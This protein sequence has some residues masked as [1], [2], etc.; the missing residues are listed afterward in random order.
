M[1]YQKYILTRSPQQL[2]MYTALVI[3]L[4]FLLPIRNAEAKV[5]VTTAK[6]SN[7]KFTDLYFMTR[8]GKARFGSYDPFFKTSH[9]QGDKSK[10]EEGTETWNRLFRS[11]V[12]WPKL[13]LIKNHPE[14]FEGIKDFGAN[15]KPCGISET[16]HPAQMASGVNLKELYLTALAESLQKD[17]YKKYF[18]SD[19]PLF[20][21]P[22]LGVEPYQN[23]CV[24]SNVLGGMGADEFRLRRIHN[25]LATGIY[26]EFTDYAKKITLPSSGYL[27]VPSPLPDYDFSNKVF[28]M[29]LD[30]GMVQ[31]SVIQPKNIGVRPFY[32]WLPT[33]D[34]EIKAAEHPYMAKNELD[35]I[36]QGFREGL[37]L[38][39]I[40]WTLDVEKAEAVSVTAQ[41]YMSMAQKRG[42]GYRY[43][44]KSVFGVVEVKIL[45]RPKAHFDPRLF[46][47]RDLYT[48]FHI[49]KPEIEFF[50]DSDLTESLGVASLE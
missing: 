19:N 39:S 33:E 42:D 29:G 31:N 35:E 22:C 13:M 40:Q 4:L 18:C 1:L 2:L 11:Q 3:L 47:D 5:E 46:R 34:F 50:S 6:S 45:D 16:L 8:N 10:Y 27:V 14:C 7:E 37:K 38:R 36:K 21:C 15:L 43:R 24:R 44:A 49:T 17:L 25:E 30:Y 26:A 41:Q 20:P 23:A 48:Y 32:R 12:L 28:T 9:P